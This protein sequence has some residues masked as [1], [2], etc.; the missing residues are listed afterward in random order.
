M[1]SPIQMVGIEVRQ[2]KNG[3]YDWS[4]DIM[5]HTGERDAEG[6]ALGFKSRTFF[7]PKPLTLDRARRMQLALLDRNT[8]IE[9][10]AKSPLE[11]K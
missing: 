11:L 4:V 10:N 8:A 1:K 7:H 6:N 9:E 2:W 3:K 5:R